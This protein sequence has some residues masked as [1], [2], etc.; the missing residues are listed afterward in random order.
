MHFQRH[1]RS[2][3]LYM[4]VEHI[5]FATFVFCLISS[6]G[7]EIL[8]LLCAQQQLDT[9]RLLFVDIPFIPFQQ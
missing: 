7:F 9:D 5:R 4:P 2:L 8:F 6:V 3:D 1:T